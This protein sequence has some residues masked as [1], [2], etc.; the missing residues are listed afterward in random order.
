MSGAAE[1]FAQ[2]I[3]KYDGT[4]EGNAGTLKNSASVI[5]NDESTLFKTLV[6]CLGRP[7]LR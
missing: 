7:Q 2:I 6:N 5:F 3:D 1:V 4:A